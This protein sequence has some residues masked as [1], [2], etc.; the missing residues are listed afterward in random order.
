[1]RRIIV[2]MYMYKL[3]IIIIIVERFNG[4]NFCYHSQQNELVNKCLEKG[5]I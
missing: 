1:M 4:L 5:V 2:M 3:Y